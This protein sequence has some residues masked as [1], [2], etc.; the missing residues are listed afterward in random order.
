MK[1]GLGRTGVTWMAALAVV[2]LMGAPAA[3][4]QGAS[5][6]GTVTRAGSGDALAG[7]T[8][9]LEEL[10]RTTRTAVDGS[11]RFD[12]L[13]PGVYHLS[14]RAEGYS[15]RRAE[16]DVP[17]SGAT[18]NVE[19]EFDLHFYEV[20]SVS[21][22]PRPQFESYQPTSVLAGQ[23]LA[24]QLEG[25]IGA[26]LASQ[27][28]V[29][30]RALGSGPARPVI[31]G[32]DG[33]RV[34]VLQDGQRTGDISSQSGDHGVVVNPASAERIE[35]V[36]GPA[37]LLYGASAIGGLVNVITDQI[38][39]APV[40]GAS[41]RFTF[42]AG[43][44]AEEGA[45]A[46]DVHFGNGTWAL[47]LGGGGRRVG[48]FSTPDGLVENSQS[49]SGFFSVGGAWTGARTY[50]GASVAY[51]DTKYGI[52]LLPHE[53]ED[54]HDDEE[55]GEHEEEEEEVP[56][57]L[58]PK[59]QAFTLRSGGQNLDG[60]VSS[61]R[62]TLGVKRYEH[63]EFEGDEVGTIFGNDTVE[64]EVLL[65]HR[66]S[67]RLTGTLGGWFHNRQFEAIGPEALSPPVDQRNVAVFFYEEMTWPHATLQ[68]GG[69]LDRVSFEPE[70]DLPAR[71]FTNVSGSVGLL[72]RPQAASDNLVIAT[73]VAHA[74]RNPAL[75]E[76]YF[77]GTHFGNRSFEIG[78]PN[79]DSER[80]LG[81]DVSLRART[82][83]FRGEFTVFRNDVQDFIFRSPLTEDEFEAREEEFEERFG[84]HGEE[85][86]D[87]HG[88][89][90]DFPFVEFVGADSVLWG[91]EAHADVDLG[92]GLSA[93]FT[94]DWVRGQLKATSRPLPRIPPYRLITGLRY[95]RNAFQFGGSMTIAGE[96]NR[97][98]GAETL[99]D[100]YTVFRGFAA[101]SFEAGGV[102]NTVTA[103]LEN[104]TDTLYRNHLN[105]RKDDLPEMGR[106]FRLVYTLG[107]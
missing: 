25:T 21:P 12:G 78:D 90:G 47:H 48:E 32:L 86:E 93:E 20:V 83:R 100:G 67:G 59:R 96:Q 71:D 103:R 36:R 106:N 22:S 65:S 39:A 89:E 24:K 68:F 76:L 52:P 50:V 94:Y 18:L 87:G 7:A 80:A 73:S 84:G 46:G 92:A 10:R 13:T 95:Q 11:Y 105:F 55:E 60:F 27:P 35:V 82:G 69:R 91:F 56:I 28:G 70:D 34:V 3:A 19:V 107:F 14:V 45:G 85:E 63:T 64:A 43:S 42:D 101:Y 38:P 4:E 37:T 44:N 1:S 57:T 99:T 53:D 2:L 81:I 6:S 72:L 5:L 9:I 58:T 8:V 66:P 26:T 61:Y 16:I 41:G 97:V 54:G 75:E 33:D 40:R 104:A 77:F 49:R 74:S 15:S 23:D 30:M 51:D 88:H 79:L 17:A 98:S 102:L 62:A 31:R 29:A